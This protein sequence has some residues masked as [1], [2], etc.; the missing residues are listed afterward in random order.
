MKLEVGQPFLGQRG[1]RAP[2]VQ[3]SL[4]GSSPELHLI[5]ERP[6][7]AEVNAI[8]GGKAEFGVYEE[9]GLLFFLYQFGGGVIP[10][11]DTPY[12]RAAEDAFRAVNL[13]LLREQSRAVLL[14]ILVDASNS[15]IRGLRTVSISPEVTRA[16][17][18]AVE[19]QEAVVN[20]EQRLAQVYARR[21]SEEMA[22]LSVSCI[23]GT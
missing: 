21:S 23:G 18:M 17:W 5:L 13:Q 22:A 14:V 19:L 11:S 20:Y 1:A 8:R 9:D 15:I 6:T 3:L 10:W 12:S 2:G 7:T 16:L 4:S